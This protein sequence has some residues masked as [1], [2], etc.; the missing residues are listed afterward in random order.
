VV[1][2]DA[3][4]VVFGNGFSNEE[5]AVEVYRQHRTLRGYFLPSQKTMFLE[6]ELGGVDHFNE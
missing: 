5:G 3:L 6:L 1:V 2:V 4:C